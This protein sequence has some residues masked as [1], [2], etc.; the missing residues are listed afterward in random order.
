MEVIELKY[1]AVIDYL[2][3]RKPSRDICLS[4]GISDRT[5]RRWAKRYREEGYSGLIPRPKAPKQVH[6]KLPEEDEILVIDAKLRN[7]AAGA[8]RLSYILLDETGKEFNY[9]TIHRVL[10]RN[11]LH[12]RIKPKK[13][14]YRRF[15]RRHPDSLW[16]MDIYEFR[17]RGV[18]KVRVF[19]IIDD[20]SR[21]VPALRIYKRK[22]AANAVDTLAHALATGRKPKALYEP[23]AFAQNF[24]NF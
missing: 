23:P 19:G 14:S 10:D 12:I 6:N 2:D 7:P 21:F 20:H 13:V 11:G 15:E 22:T 5:L 1:R 3:R 16:Q 18:G 9:R 24:P 8:R 17:I 4:L